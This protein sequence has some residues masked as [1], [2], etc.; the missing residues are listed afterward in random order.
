M[1]QETYNAIHETLKDISSLMSK[2]EAHKEAIKEALTALSSEHNI[3][4]RQL[5]RMAKVYHKQNFMEECKNNEE[6]ETLYE[7]VMKSRS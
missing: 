5:S 2:A 1:S 3:P 7:N 4:K 6:F